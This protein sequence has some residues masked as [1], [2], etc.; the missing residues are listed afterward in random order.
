MRAPASGPRL[1]YDG[2]YLWFVY[3][4]ITLLGLLLILMQT[5]CLNKQVELKGHERR[6]W[7]SM[8]VNHQGLM[9]WLDRYQE[10]VLEQAQMD[11]LATTSDED[12]PIL[13]WILTAPWLINLT[14]YVL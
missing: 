11:A 13:S 14:C 3:I 8:Q 5:H 2:R 7:R 9:D 10:V 1:G 6:E 12:L 4:P